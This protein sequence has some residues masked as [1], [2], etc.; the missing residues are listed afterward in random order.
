MNMKGA[1]QMADATRFRFETSEMARTAGWGITSMAQI[2]RF[3]RAGVS[4]EVVYSTKDFIS[5][6][7]RDGPGSE[8]SHI[9]K[10]TVAKIDLLRLWLT[11]SRSNVISQSVK[12]AAGVDW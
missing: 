5:E 3:T 4:I 12:R 11:G 9:P 2:D 8:H 6:F 7:F 1:G 10:R